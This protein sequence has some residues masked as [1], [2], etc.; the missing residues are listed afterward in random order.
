MVP[1]PTTGALI[2]AGSLLLLSRGNRRR[3]ARV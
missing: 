3:Y 1:E 2:L